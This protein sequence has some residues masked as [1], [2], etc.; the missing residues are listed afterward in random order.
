MQE[1]PLRGRDPE[2]R[3]ADVSFLEAQPRHRTRRDGS[4]RA[5]NSPIISA[6]EMRCSPPSGSSRGRGFLLGREGYCC[7]YSFFLSLF[8][9]FASWDPYLKTAAND[10]VPIWLRAQSKEVTHLTSLSGCSEVG[11][12]VSGLSATLPSISLGFLSHGGGSQHL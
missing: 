7:R 3:W 10:S 11:I 6:T 8:S 4:P 5:R 12:P 1:S 2:R 9:C